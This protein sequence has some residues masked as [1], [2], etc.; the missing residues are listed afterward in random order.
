L[1]WLGKRNFDN[2]IILKGV[3]ELEVFSRSYDSVLEV[4]KQLILGVIG[5]VREVEN[6]AEN[7]SRSAANIREQV[8]LMEELSSQIAEAA[9]QISNDAEDISEAVGSN[10]D[11]IRKIVEDENRMVESPNEA[12]KSIEDSASGVEGSS[13]EMAEMIEK[14]RISVDLGEDLKRKAGDIASIAETVLSIAEQTNLLA[15]NAAIEAARSGEA[16]RGFAVVADEIR[17]LAEES[18]RSADKIAQF[19]KSVS[20]GITDLVDNLGKEFE[21]VKALADHLKENSNR[22]KE[23]SGMISS[24]AHRMNELMNNLTKES[25]KLEGTTTNIQNFLAISEEAAT[26]EEISASIQKFLTELK[27]VL[28]DVTK[29]EKYI[30]VLDERTSTFKV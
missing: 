17:K 24:I 5:D 16:G 2:P 22:N 13:D 18:R 1:N 29:V 28:E 8:K 26:A 15:P 3:R 12:V 7:V 21:K 6:F 25:E 10:V 19:L 14:F 23:A 20:E 27:V 4:V 11:V 9:V 30:K